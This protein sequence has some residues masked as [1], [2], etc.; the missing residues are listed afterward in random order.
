MRLSEACCGDNGV[1]LTVLLFRGRWLNVCRTCFWAGDTFAPKL[2][3]KNAKGEEVSI[4]T[5]LQSAFLS[6]WEVLAK[7][8]G[9]LDGV[10]GF[11]V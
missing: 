2:K 10:I 9:D 7:A 6:A 3:V 1:G 5:L 8:V 4:Q 11:E